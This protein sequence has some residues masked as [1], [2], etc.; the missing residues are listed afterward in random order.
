MKKQIS[1]AVRTLA[2]SMVVAVVLSGTAMGEVLF[3]DDF[4]DTLTWTTSDNSVYIK[5]NDF[6]YIGSDGEYDDFAEKTFSIDLSNNY[7]IIIEQRIKLESSGR[8]YTLSNQHIY[9]EDDKVISVTYLPSAQYGWNLGGWTKNHDNAIPGEGYWAVT[10]IIITPNGGELYLKP[11]DSARGWF[12]NDFVK[13]ASKDW[14]YNRITKIVFRQHWDSVNYFDYIKIT[15][16]YTVLQ[17]VSPISNGLV[18]EWHFDGDAK[19]SSGNGNDG[20]IYGATFVDGVSD[21]ALSFDGV[22][23]YVNCGNDESLEPSSEEITVS[24]WVYLNNLKNYQHVIIKG[25]ARQQ[26]SYILQVREDGSL[27]FAIAD[28]ADSLFHQHV[29]S[30]KG[31]ISEGQWYHIAGTYKKT[32]QE[33]GLFINGK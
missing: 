8:D 24:A 31:M 10:K 32:G 29:N 19:D 3:S 23:D 4:K 16:E 6:L 12:S 30:A 25:D 2:I 15:K 13:V 17:P 28:E 9:F 18:A 1:I 5:D 20:V 7:N 27:V 21:K 22:D 33:F 14:S 11:D 26:E